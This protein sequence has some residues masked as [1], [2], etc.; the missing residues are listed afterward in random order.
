[1]KFIEDLDCGGA[2]LGMGPPP[3]P[4]DFE[5]VQGMMIPGNCPD[6]VCCGVRQGF[7]VENS[8]VVELGLF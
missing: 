7:L 4:R 8:P 1:M 5:G 3:L 6:W 2:C